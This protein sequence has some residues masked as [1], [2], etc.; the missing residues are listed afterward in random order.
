LSRKALAW[1]FGIP[2][3]LL[4]VLGVTASVYQ[5]YW[6]RGA[7]RAVVAAAQGLAR[8]EE[9]QRLKLAEFVQGPDLAHA[10][11]SGFQ[12]SGFDNIGVGFRAY[13]V[14]LRVA[15]G[16]QYNFDAY[17]LDGAWQLSCCTKWSEPELR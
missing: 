12:V 5:E 6:L 3:A 14:K 1:S 15:N 16:D 17:Y 11:G 13:E 10:F 7:E 2:V 4:A 8:G 9:V